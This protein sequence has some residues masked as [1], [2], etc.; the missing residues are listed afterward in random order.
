M[1][2]RK[3]EPDRNKKEKKGFVDRGILVFENTS[4]VIQA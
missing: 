4:E 3:K 1:F 2:F